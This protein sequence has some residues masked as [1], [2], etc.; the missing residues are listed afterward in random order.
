MVLINSYNHSS[1]LYI[2]P[3][4]YSPIVHL[5]YGDRRPTS[6]ARIGARPMLNCQSPNKPDR[7]LGLPA[8]AARSDLTQPRTSSRYGLMLRALSW[9]YWPEKRL[10]PDNMTHKLSR[11]TSF[12]RVVSSTLRLVRIMNNTI[13]PYY[14]HFIITQFLPRFY[15]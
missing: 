6:A 7:G 15:T 5:G 14:K 10:T 13:F 12:L 4:N 3:V 2:I 8:S 9:G 11:Y 1:Q